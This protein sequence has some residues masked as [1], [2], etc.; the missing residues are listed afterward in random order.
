[1]TKKFDTWVEKKNGNMVTPL[2]RAAFVA[3]LKPKGMSNNPEGE[4]KYSVTMIFPKG[5]DHKPLKDYIMRIAKEKWG[6]KGA[7]IIKRQEASDKR[8]FKDGSLM[9]EKYAGF[10]EGVPY[11]SAS[12]KEKPNLV[13]T[14]AGPSGTLVELTEESDFVSG[15]YAIASVRPYCWDNKFGKGV[16]LSLQNVQKIKEGERLGG[17]RSKAN[18]DFEPIE[19][20]DMELSE[21][22]VASSEDPWA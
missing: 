7:D 14:Q 13:G 19:D 8:I 4:K 5:T 15:Y 10:E 16:S 6:E 17:G 3:L 21:S 20:D 1:M 22:S 2:F 11:L 18:E 12:N 9:A